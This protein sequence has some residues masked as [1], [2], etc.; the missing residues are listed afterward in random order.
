MTTDT[1]K[2]IR[3]AERE[4]DQTV[5]RARLDGADAL[6]RAQAD[7]EQRIKDESSKLLREFDEEIFLADKEAESLFD[8]EEIASYSDA[9][10]FRKKSEA[11][12]PDAVRFIVG[13]IIEKWQ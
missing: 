7:S 12:L 10:K 11:R 1:I 3:A 2:K 6:R 4:A 5:E 9:E 13:G 8:E